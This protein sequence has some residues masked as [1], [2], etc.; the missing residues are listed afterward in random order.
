MEQSQ[1]EG[2]IDCGETDLGDVREETVMGMPVEESQAAME[3][4]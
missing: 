3:A 1:G 4:G 2:S